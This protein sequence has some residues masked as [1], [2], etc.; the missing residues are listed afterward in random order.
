M[1]TTTPN[2]GLTKPAGNEDVDIAPL[3]S[4]F[5]ILD[6]AAKLRVADG[7]APAVSVNQLT[8]LDNNSS[9]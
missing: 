8:L 7:S 4:N 2:L 9:L 3:N 5:D 1:S 6:A